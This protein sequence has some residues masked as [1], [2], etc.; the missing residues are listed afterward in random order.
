MSKTSKPIR[1]GG[2][3]KRCALAAVLLAA[4]CTLRPEPLPNLALSD[5]PFRHVD[6]ASDMN[7]GVN[8][9]TNVGTN[10]GIKAGASESTQRRVD[11]LHV[12][13]RATLPAATAGEDTR[14][15]WVD[16]FDD[17]VL[18]RLVE[19]AVNQN[20]EI[21]AA[22]ARVA[23]AKAILDIDTSYTKPT[24]QIGGTFNRSR[25]S[26]EI[27]D[28]LP[29]RTLHNWSVPLDVRYEIDVWGRISG[30]AMSAEETMCAV[31]ADR[32]AVTLRIATQISSDYLTLRFVDVDRAELLRSIALRKIALDLIL[33]RARAGYASDLDTLRAKTELKTASADL[34][35]SDRL[36]E[37]LVDAI[38]VLTGRSVTDVAIDASQVQPTVPA[39]PVGLPS[40]IMANRPDIDAARYRLDAAS[41]RIGIAKTAFLPSM[42]LNASGGFASNSLRTFLDKNSSLWSLGMSVTEAVFDGGRRRAGVDAAKADY[43]IAAS[44][45]RATVLEAFRQVQDALNGIATARR[46]V[47]DFDEA[48]TSSAQAAMLSRSRYEHGYVSYFEVVDA[49]RSALAIKRQLIRSRQ[50]QAMATLSLLQALGGRWRGNTAIATRDTRATSTIADQ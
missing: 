7:A 16:A 21:R 29:K 32:E 2:G 17:P 15:D 24:V 8:V 6:A 45:Y 1:G 19:S 46:E 48:A 35:E 20:L 39:I 41:L 50:A 10:V 5:R 28:A 36:R 34:A 30:E 43:A 9:G 3:A 18:T 49:D 42:T 22:E 40:E 23:Q 4:G 33:G 13:T 11:A 31:D 12:V 14:W 47:S 38:A 44:G 26:G 37:N 27:D 25:V